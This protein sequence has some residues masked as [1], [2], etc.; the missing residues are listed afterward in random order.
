MTA[1]NDL[2]ELERFGLLQSQ[3]VR[4][5]K[6]YHP[7]PKLLKTKRVVRYARWLRG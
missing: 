2:A 6:R 4:K 1:R 3:R 5:V 7:A